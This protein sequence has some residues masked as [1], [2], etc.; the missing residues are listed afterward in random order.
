MTSVLSFMTKSAQWVQKISAYYNTTEQDVFLWWTLQ[1]WNPN[2]QLLVTLQCCEPLSA[3]FLRTLSAFCAGLSDP[4]LHPPPSGEH[5][6]HF[7]TTRSCGKAWVIKNT[8][9]MDGRLSWVSL[10]MLACT[11]GDNLVA[12]SLLLRK[13]SKS[14]RK[15]QMGRST[16]VRSFW[17][18][19]WDTEALDPAFEWVII[20]AKCME[21]SVECS[22]L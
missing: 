8:F 21:I 9:L 11:V 17:S 5:G 7:G 14:H 10:F 4:D 12:M 6:R 20:K 1:Q 19:H 13:L 18:C 3:T 15:Q 2:F 16:L 22:I